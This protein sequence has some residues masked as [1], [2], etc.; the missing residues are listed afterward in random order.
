MARQRNWKSKEPLSTIDD[1]RTFIREGS[2]AFREVHDGAAPSAAYSEWMARYG[3]MP[4]SEDQWLS[5]RSTFIT[6]AEEFDKGP[7]MQMEEFMRRC[8]WLEAEYVRK[9][10]AAEKLPPRRDGKQPPIPSPFAR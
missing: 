8:S 7:E 9:M 2:R 6:V 3:P 5:L 1:S 4:V 10:R